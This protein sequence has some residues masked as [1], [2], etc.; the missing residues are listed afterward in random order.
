[1]SIASIMVSLDLGRSAAD[2]VRLAADLAG[3]FEAGLTGLAARTIDAPAP[4]GDIVTAQETYAKDRAA[5]VDALARAQDVFERN[6]GAALRR[7]WRQAEADP[8]AY[9]IQQARGADLVVLGRDPRQDGADAMG[10]APGAV[11]M[12]VGR[13]VLVVPPGVDRL[14][15]ARIVVAWKD[16]PEARRAVTAALPFIALADQVFV[17][18]AGREARLEGAEEVSDFLARH[19]VHVTTHR[20]DAA[21]GDIADAIIRFAGR[22]D[23]DLVVMGAYGHSRLRE[24]LLGGMTRS[25]LQTSPLCCLMSH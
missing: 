11:L 9:L 20:L 4:V 17:V 5:L 15:A 18:S 2:R 7:E 12:E 16:G 14:K 10:A 22:H 3:R 25:I 21:A 23:A 1:M 6:G 13:P 24:W 8:E 19:G